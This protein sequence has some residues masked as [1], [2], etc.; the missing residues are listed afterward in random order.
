MAAHVQQR[1]PGER[2]GGRY[3]NAVAR[4]RQCPNRPGTFRFTSAVTNSR[5]QA[6]RE[7]A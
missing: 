1:T 7:R 6:R 3:G 5:S 4:N 2:F